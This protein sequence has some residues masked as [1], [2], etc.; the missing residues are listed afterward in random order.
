[1]DITQ[2]FSW[3]GAIG[4]V[5]LCLTIYAFTL[6]VRTVVEELWKNAKLNK[7]WEEM[8]VPLMPLV[9]GLLVGLVSSFPWPD[10]LGTA[11]INH[12]M[13]G[14][15]CGMF[16]AWVYARVK[17]FLKTGEDAANQ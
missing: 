8:A 3:S 7:L 9:F 15:V 4:T 10:V 6:M 5:I 13:Y 16:S 11:V 2:F 17:A 12:M 14:M 1:M